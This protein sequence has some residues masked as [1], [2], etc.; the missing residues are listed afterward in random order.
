MFPHRAGGKAGPQSPDRETT[1]PTEAQLRDE[2]VGKG[3]SPPGVGGRPV[4]GLRGAR[5]RG[6]DWLGQGKE[7]ETVQFFFIS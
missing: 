6:E 1:L 5:E 3:V 7:V 2:M 4:R